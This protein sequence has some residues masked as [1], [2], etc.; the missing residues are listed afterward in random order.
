MVPVMVSIRLFSEPMA[1]RMRCSMCQAVLMVTPYL[2]ST[3]R[4]LM[5]FLAVTMS[6]MTRTQVRIGIFV[7]CRIVSVSTENCLRQSRHFQTRR[8][9]MV[10]AA[11][12]RLALL[13]GT[14]R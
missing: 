13:S 5:P 11:V 7:A 9:L 1:E 3:S 6:K 8:S 12:L 2:R 4:A 10:P 14:I